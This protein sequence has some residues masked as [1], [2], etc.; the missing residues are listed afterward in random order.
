MCLNVTA[1]SHTLIVETVNTVNTRTFV[2]AAENEE[3]FGVFD[4]RAALIR[5][6]ILPR[7]S[8]TYLVRQKQTNSLQRLLASIHVVAKE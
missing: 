4:L 3:V 7:T 6:D 1:I 2:V 5:S 8:R